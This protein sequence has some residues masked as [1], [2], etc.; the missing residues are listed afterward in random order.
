MD[1]TKIRLKE[2]FQRNGEAGLVVV[3]AHG[4]QHRLMMTAARERME[5]RWNEIERAQADLVRWWE[6]EANVNRDMAFYVAESDRLT[7]E[8]E[9]LEALWA[10]IISDGQAAHVATGRR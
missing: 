6:S 3:D 10:Q 7:A 8:R 5:A 9:R 1:I 2:T 4:Q